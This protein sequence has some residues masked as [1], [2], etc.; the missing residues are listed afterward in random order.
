MEKIFS[1]GDI[2]SGADFLLQVKK[3]F[4][5]DVSEV[6]GAYFDGEKIFVVRL[7][8]K[9]ETIELDA[10]GSDIEHLAEKISLAC[11][12]R[13]WKTSAVGLCLREG[14]A[15]TYQTA[16]GNLPE[17]EIPAMVKSWA[18]AQAGKDAAFSF[19]KVGSELWME[20]LPRK[21]LQEICAA[22]DKFGL[23]LR[24]LSVM[25]VD[26]LTKVAPFDRTEFISEVVRNKKAPNFLAAGSL[27]NWKK[28]SQAVA[29]IF[30][31]ALTVAT[32]KIFWNYGAASDELDAA[33]LAVDE[34]NADVALKKTIDAD[35]A[36][37]HRLNKIAAAQVNTPTKFN[38][39]LNL[40]RIADKTV[41]LTKIHAD[42]N[43][44]ELEGVTNTPDAVK[45]YLARVKNSVAPTARLESSAERD[46]KIVFT[47]RATS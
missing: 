32:L 20:T 47:I 10:T 4:R 13:D 21:T 16:I 45:S 12:E 9:F 11:K 6:V 17:K 2:L 5:E 27:W 14:D 15:V 42:G 34:L 39:L 43:S 29:A 22:F 41:R 3:F 18:L 25:P 38:L 26:L 24:G 33:K 40:G 23:K 36:E 8:E 28:I 46:D 44:L 1:G 30:L 19:A 31:I 7:T 37:L 35:I